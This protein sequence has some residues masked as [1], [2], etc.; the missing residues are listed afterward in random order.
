MALFGPSIVEESKRDKLTDYNW[1]LL[2]DT[3][4]IFDFNEAKGKVIVIN[5]WATWCPPCIAEMPSLEALYESY[6]EDVVFLFVS[7]EE[8]KVI[9]KF[10]NKNKYSFQFHTP[11]AANPKLFQVSSIPRTFIIDKSGYI[12]IDKTGAANWNS[13]GVREQLNNLIKE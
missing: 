13:E 8:P 5:F 10:I 9:Q 6:N 4:E 3:N 7:N 11:K 12:V 2:S 1:E